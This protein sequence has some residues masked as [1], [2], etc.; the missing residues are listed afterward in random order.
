MLPGLNGKGYTAS[1]NIKGNL[2][3][4]VGTVYRGSSLGDPGE[5][6]GFVVASK[7]DTGE[8]A[9][10]YTLGV[11]GSI[12]IKD[13][14]IQDSKL[15]VASKWTP[16]TLDAGF[17]AI[18]SK[19]ELN[20]PSITATTTAENPTGTNTSS[21]E[22]IQENPVNQYISKYKIELIMLAVIVILIILLIARR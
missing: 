8:L 2:V 22:Q 1:I 3:I 15:V 4:S 20:Q 11:K 9:G 13:S 12:I 19:H 14:T 5:S 7:L 6:K 18:E 21:N 10:A 17:Q 16:G